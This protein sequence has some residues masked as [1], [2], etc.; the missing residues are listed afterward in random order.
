MTDPIADMIIRIKNALL[1][2]RNEVRIPHSKLKKAMAQL[3]VDHGYIESFEVVEMLP[4]AE[5]VVKPKYVGKTPAITQ[6]RR[7]SRP[8]RRVYAT[9]RQIPR[10]LGGYGLTIVSTSKG[11]VSDKAARKQN[12]GGEV[13]CQIW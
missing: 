8:G 1:A 9:A 4:Q 5:I 6:V 2:G 3:L 13:I 11:L 10:A 12:L 7:V